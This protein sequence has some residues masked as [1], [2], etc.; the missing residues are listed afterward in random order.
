MDAKTQYS[1]LKKSG[2][3]LEFYPELTGVWAEDKKAF[4]QIYEL[5]INGIIDDYEEL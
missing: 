3:L 4:T 2:D 1:I 5:T